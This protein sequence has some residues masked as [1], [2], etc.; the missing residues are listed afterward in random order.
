[1]SEALVELTQPP[2]PYAY[3]RLSELAT[4]VANA[5]EGLETTAAIP[6]VLED[7][8]LNYVASAIRAYGSGA[9]NKSGELEFQEFA[10][11]EAG[12]RAFTARIITSEQTTDDGPGGKF[13]TL[14]YTTGVRDD[15]E[16]RTAIL[17]ITDE[18]S[19]LNGDAFARDFRVTHLERGRTVEVEDPSASVVVLANLIHVLGMCI[20]QC[21]S[22]LALEAE[23]AKSARVYD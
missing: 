23:Q 6:G 18:G 7:I 22:D 11:H 16:Q 14:E 13:V 21:A 19:L 2:T 4:E 3:E 9:R 20:Q 10:L 8:D 12:T 15:R 17:P 1:M 5:A